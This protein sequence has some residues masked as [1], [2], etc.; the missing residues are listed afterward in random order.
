MFTHS[1]K[2]QATS[3]FALTS[4]MYA[5]TPL[6]GKISKISNHFAFAKPL[7]KQHAD[8]NME[9]AEQ[10]RLDPPPACSPPPGVRTAA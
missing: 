7:H 3:L 8:V 6:G 4:W 10:L 5:H 9:Q 1:G 2:R